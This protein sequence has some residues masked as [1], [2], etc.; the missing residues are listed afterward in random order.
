M[1]RATDIPHGIADADS[2]VLGR[3]RHYGAFFGLDPLPADF[4]V[5]VGNCQAESLRIVLDAPDRPLM[6]VPP[7][8]EM[9]ASE[10]ERLHEI[11]ARAAYVVSQPIRRD[12]RD[13]PLGT[14]QLTDS[15]TPGARLITV[16]SVRFTGLH[17]FQAAIRVPGIAGDPPLV[18]YHDVRL[19]A[20]VAGA[21]VAPAL[22]PDAVRAVA[23]DALAELRRREAEIDVPVSDLFTPVT[24]D[25]MRTVNHPGNPVWLPLAARVI[26]VLGLAGEPTDPGRPLLASVQAPLEGWVVETWGLPDAPRDHWLVDGNPLTTDA[27]HE[28]HRTWYGA[29]PGFVDAALTRLAPLMRHWRS[30]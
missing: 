6:R 26:D 24:A 23:D 1:S 5:V 19:L 30:A 14:A 13:L 9:T 17:P 16:P 11:V 12:Y 27:V 4:G 3:R 20:E 8:H 18:A 29:H 7:V 21:P 10:A 28:A 15:L 25:H 2:S 22:T